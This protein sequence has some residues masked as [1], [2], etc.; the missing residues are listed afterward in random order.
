MP[1]IGGQMKTVLLAILV[2]VCEGHVGQ[3]HPKAITLEQ[4]IRRSE[5]ILV[6][7]K[8]KPFT[9][10]VKT[11]L[12]SSGKFPP[13]ESPRYAYKVVTSIKDAGETKAAVGSRIEVAPAH[14]GTMLLVARK[15]ELEGIHKSPILEFYNEK[16]WEIGKRDK[17]IVFLRRNDEGK[18]YAFT[19][20]HAVEGL[21][22]KPLLDSML[23]ASLEAMEK[24]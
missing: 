18:S 4:L 14:D 17:Y 19:A 6:V 3:I 20:D 8:A 16:G 22:K 5:C 10:I 12:D 2:F 21:E 13:Y 23:K 24:P 7:K 1:G 11:E 15:Y 9:R